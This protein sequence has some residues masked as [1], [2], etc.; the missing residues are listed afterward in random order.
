[1]F[2][3]KSKIIK[4]QQRVINSLTGVIESLKED[5]ADKTEELY[6]LQAKRLGRPRKKK[7]E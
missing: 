3:K 7:E 4:D 2:G 6:K 5:L 1:M